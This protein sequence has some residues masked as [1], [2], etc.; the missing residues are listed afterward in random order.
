AN[1]AERVSRAVSRS[2]SFFILSS[3]SLPRGGG[4]SIPSD[5]VWIVGRRLRQPRGAV[6]RAPRDS[7]PSLGTAPRLV[8]ALQLLD[9]RAVLEGAHVADQLLARRHAAQQPAHDLA[10]ARLGQ[11][12]GEAHLVGTGD[13]ADL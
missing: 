9:H 11:R 8:G 10:R 12:V 7:C 1:A 4:R 6:K 3:L 13:G 2:S 5:A